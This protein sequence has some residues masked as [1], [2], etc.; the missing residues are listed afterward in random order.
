MKFSGDSTKQY[1]V[2][3]YISGMFFILGRI[4]LCHACAPCPSPHCPGESFVALVSFPV[5]LCL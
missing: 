4:L 1:V 5:S 2:V 3:K